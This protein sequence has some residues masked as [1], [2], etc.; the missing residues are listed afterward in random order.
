MISDNK[1][2]VNTVLVSICSLGIV[3]LLVKVLRL[4]PTQIYLFAASALFA[5]YVIHEVYWKRR[6]L[7]LAPY[8]G[9]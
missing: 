9:S 5:L 6:R 3:F 4:L 7:P 2:S 8:H 1:N